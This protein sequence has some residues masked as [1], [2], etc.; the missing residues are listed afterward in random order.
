MSSVFMA[1]DVMSNTVAPSIFWVRVGTTSDF[2]EDKPT[3]TFHI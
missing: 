2:F 1:S 3:S